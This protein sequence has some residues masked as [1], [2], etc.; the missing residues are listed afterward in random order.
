MDAH[1]I[2]YLRFHLAMFFEQR[3]LGVLVLVLHLKVPDWK[4]INEDGIMK[5]Q[6][7]WKVKSFT[8]GLEFFQLVADIA[9]A[10]GS[11]SFRWSLLETNFSRMSYCY[12]LSMPCRM[13]L[14]TES[15]HCGSI[16]CFCFWVIILTFIW[17]A[18]TRR[19]N[20]K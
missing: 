19:F 8:K 18:G 16:L 11:L 4:L 2:G 15:P 14:E 5:L 20:R 6:R 3:L 10:E 9:E 7:S 1:F 17:L 12:Q 13:S